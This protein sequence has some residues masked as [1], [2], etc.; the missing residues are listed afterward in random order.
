[1]P[2]EP[3]RQVAVD[4]VRVLLRRYPDASIEVEYPVAHPWAQ[5]GTGDVR[6]CTEDCVVV[7][8]TKY[9]DFQKTGR[10]AKVRRTQHRKKVIDQC[11]TYCA[12]A[13]LQH[14]NKS[15]LGYVAT[16]EHIAPVQV[17]SSMSRAQAVRHVVTVLQN[18]NQSHVWQEPIQFLLSSL[19]DP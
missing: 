17:V 9:L 2:F 19:R 18:C 12:W 7:L 4:A 14:G 5:L 8:E 11:T 16:N 1:M 13:K 3:E 10:T 15:V 6:L